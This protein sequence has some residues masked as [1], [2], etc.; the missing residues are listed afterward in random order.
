MTHLLCSVGHTGKTS[1]LHSFYARKQNASRVFAIV[2]ASARPS[3]CPS[4]TLVSC[5]KTVQARIT[6]SSR[7]VALRSLVY[8]DK[9][10]CHWV[11]GF[12][13]NEGV[14]KDVRF[15]NLVF[16]HDKCKPRSLAVWWNFMRA[17][18][19]VSVQPI[20][21]HHRRNQGLC[22]SCCQHEPKFLEQF[23]PF[24]ELQYVLCLNLSKS[25]KM[26]R[27]VERERALKENDRLR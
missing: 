18:R 9:I 2:W 26:A 14:E 27:K 19:N 24:Y 11:Q 3:V 22:T 17:D 5:I 13:S 4:V 20:A 6:K 23:V 1:L 7:R 8:R 15:C 12:P 21:L 16:C 25:A 10:S